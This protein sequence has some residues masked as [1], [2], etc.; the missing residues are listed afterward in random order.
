MVTNHDENFVRLTS[1]L[2]HHLTS[3]ASSSTAVERCAPRARSRQQRVPAD[4]LRDVDRLRSPTFQT[5]ASLSAWFSRGFCSPKKG[6]GI[7]APQHTL[8]TRFALGNFFSSLLQFS[9]HAFA[10]SSLDSLSL[11]GCRTRGDSAFA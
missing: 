4:T 5:P 1:P 7:A 3:F 9:Q 8:P 6:E 10:W 11:V 2:Q